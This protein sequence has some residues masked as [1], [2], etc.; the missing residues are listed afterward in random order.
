[1][2][3]QARAI[4]RRPCMDSCKH[5]GGSKAGISYFEIHDSHHT[6]FNLRSTSLIYAGGLLS[7]DSPFLDVV[8]ENL[9]LA[10]PSAEFVHPLVEPPHGAALLARAKVIGPSAA[11]EVPEAILAAQGSG[12][13]GSPFGGGGQ[14]RLLERHR[15]RRRHTA[16][17]EQGGSFQPAADATILCFALCFALADVYAVHWLYSFHIA[18]I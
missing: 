14:F 18:C 17:V 2:L 8:R 4:H 6:T 1:M 9:K 13:V 5:G 16:G 15:P 7:K 12:S 10:L 3:A 11:A